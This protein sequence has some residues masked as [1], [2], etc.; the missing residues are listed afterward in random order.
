MKSETMYTAVLI[1]LALVGGYF[2]APGRELALTDIVLVKVV[3][4]AVFMAA[5]VGLL[6]A[7]RGIKYNVLSEVFDQDNSAGA[8][9][10]GL[11]LVALALV[12]K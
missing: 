5:A 2:L 7:L 11:L 4:V 9:F 10:V 8:I 1:L 3:S 12:A 6:Y